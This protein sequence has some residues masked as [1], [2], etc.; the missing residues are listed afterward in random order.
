MTVTDL[1]SLKL[2]HGIEPDAYAADTYLTDAIDTAGYYQIVAIVQFG[3][4]AGGAL[5]VKFTE[6]D[7]SGGTYTDVTSGAFS[8]FSASDDD[9]EK[10][11]RVNLNGTKRFIKVSA[12]NSNTCDFAVAVFMSPMYTGDGTTFDVEA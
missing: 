5:D 3:E 2:V 9:T 4:S 11:G 6:C 1:A 12:T 7:T 8:Q 10:I